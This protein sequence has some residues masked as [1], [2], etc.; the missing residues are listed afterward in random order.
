[1]VVRRGSNMSAYDAFAKPMDGIRTR[2]TAGGIITLIASATA[3]ILFISQLFL[4]SQ[5]EHRHSL[6]LTESKTS[7]VLTPDRSVTSKEI[8]KV[9]NKI[10]VEV[11]VTFPYMKCADMDFSHDN[12]SKSS[13]NFQKIHGRDTF[14]MR[15]PTADEFGK[16][17]GWDTSNKINANRQ[18]GCTLKGKIWISKVGGTLEI[19]MTRDAWRRYT[20]SSMFGITGMGVGDMNTMF[21]KGRDNVSHYIHSITFGEQYPHTPNPLSD[22]SFVMSEDLGVGVSNI[23]VRLVQTKYKRFGRSPRDMYQVSV[24]KHIVQPQT[25]AAQHSSSY[26][27]MS[28]TYDFTPLTVHHVEQRENFAVFISSLVSIVGGVFVTVG[29]V[30]GCLRSSAAVVSKKLD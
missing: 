29:L 11:H 25:L 1:M 22:A 14:L 10:P 13:G 21:G 24:A 6:H 12:A 3:V 7:S 20:S 16:A 8:N 26:P 4:Y 19:M 5:V 27:G 18:N 23:N 15:P 17:T 2:S 30:G 28:L 9:M